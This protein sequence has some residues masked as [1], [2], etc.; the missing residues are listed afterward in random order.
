MAS[1]VCREAIT[2]ANNDADSTG[3]DCDAG[4]GPDTITFTVNGTIA[5]GSAL[6]DIISEMTIDGSGQSVTVSGEN[7]VRVFFVTAAG[8]LTVDTLTIAN[9]LAPE[10]GGIYN[11]G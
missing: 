5:L 9:G 1:V 2:N 8:N 4:S 11:L 10:G 7:N 6:P 3:T